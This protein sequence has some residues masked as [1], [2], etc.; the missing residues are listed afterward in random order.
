MISEINLSWIT[1][2]ILGSFA[3]FFRS[4]ASDLFLFCTKK[5]FQLY[6]I[7]DKNTIKMIMSNVADN[8]SRRDEND[9]PIGIFFGYWYIGYLSESSNKMNKFGKSDNRLYIYC[10]KFFYKSI[11]GK[12]E[13]RLNYINYLEKS[14]DGYSCEW[15]EHSW[16]VVH[17]L[18]K[19]NQ[20][21]IIS[22]IILNFTEN[23]NKFFCIIHGPPGV[24]KSMI[25]ILL[26]K[27][28]KGTLV[29]SY[30]PT[31]PF[32]TL[33]GIY[34]Q[35]NPTQENPLI[36]VIDEID[37]ILKSIHSGIKQKPNLPIEVTGKKEW[38]ILFDNVDLG[39]YEHTYIIGTMNS[40]PE[41]INKLD[42]AY[43]RENRVHKIYKIGMDI[44]IASKDI[45]LKDI[46]S[47]DR[48]LKHKTK[49]TSS[50]KKIN[51]PSRFM[52]ST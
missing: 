36:I 43:I 8:S 31:L 23:K 21:E 39:L 52:K 7:R 16:N 38:N 9:K 40:S 10:T 28:V 6:E 51:V 18:A 5:Y 15:T 32:H 41:D 11:C 49:E 34:Y 29:R 45:P 19:D 33:K 46:E 48:V 42:E 24:G 25:G 22:D 12:V 13:E 47:K 2:S 50:K 3:F 1:F 44:E 37:C 35:A 20:K 17:F 14:D 27:E 4:V 26:T 30:N